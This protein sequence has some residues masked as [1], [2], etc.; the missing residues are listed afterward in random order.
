VEL[1]NEVPTIN[2]QMHSN[3][4]VWQDVSVLSFKFMTQ[5]TTGSKDVKERTDGRDGIRVLN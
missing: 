4:P 2:Q 5:S 3:R 1:G